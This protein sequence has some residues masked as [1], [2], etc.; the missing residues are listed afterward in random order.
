MEDEVRTAERNDPPVDDQSEAAYRGFL[1]ADLRRYTAFVERHGDSAAAD[2]LDAYRELM[3]SEVARHAGAEIRTEGDSFYVV[4][5][6]ARRAVACGL[7]IVSAADRAS[8]D[9]PERPIR[10]GIGINAGET[11][12]RG[13]GFVGSAVNLAAR[14]CAQA[15]EGE[16]LVTPAVRDAVGAG[17]GLRFSSRGTRRLK[18][19][20]RAIPLF[21]VEP[22][23][24]SAR[25][26]WRLPSSASVPW[27]AAAAVAAASLL[28]LTVIVAVGDWPVPRPQA[29]AGLSPDLQTPNSPAGD[30]SAT[31]APFVDPNAYP[32]AA[33]SALL[34]ALDASIADYCVRAGD[35]D[36]PVYRI[37]PGEAAVMGTTARLPINVNGGLRCEIPSLT[38][39]DV[40]HL[41]ATRSTHGVT[42]DGLPQALI[43]NDAGARIIPRGD[44]ADQNVAY[45]QWEIGDLSGWLLCREDF[46][47]A[48][49][50]WSY[51]GHAVYGTAIRQD[52][53]LS[54]L[55]EWWR[56]EARLL[57]P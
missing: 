46:G 14:V 52:G 13:E 57:R 7:A 22:G 6:S 54:A 9:R 35:D 24:A 32:N 49:L 19:V 1:F 4:F 51:D 50:T 11:V 55:L 37:D 56:E 17:A 15:H 18:G 45:G 20:A 16:V 39:P 5:G 28:T 41:W 40:V 21:A 38:A 26:S 3:R 12:Q 27:R 29:G 23:S 25:W 34:A 33:E 44:C 30:P 53:D 10:V 43:L 2:L 36:R 47:N 31:V 48:V 8:R 42:S